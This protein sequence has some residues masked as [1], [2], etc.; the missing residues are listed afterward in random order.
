MFHTNK[1]VLYKRFLSAGLCGCVNCPVKF[2]TTYLCLLLISLLTS[3]TWQSDKEQ[4]Y[5]GRICRAVVVTVT[6][7]CVSFASKVASCCF[8][9]K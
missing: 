8:N 4:P 5:Y 2:Y 9:F 7:L 1:G 6:G 3:W